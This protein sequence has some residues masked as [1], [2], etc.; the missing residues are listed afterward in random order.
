MIKKI[1]IVALG[2]CMATCLSAQKKL[3][4]KK[5]VK[6][7]ER[8]EA[9]GNLARAAE[10]YEQAWQKKNS[11]K[12]LIFKAADLYYKIK[13]YRKA[14][15]SYEYVKNDNDDFPLVGLKF[16]RS[17]KQDGQ[18][19]KAKSAFQ[20]FL[21]AYSGQGKSILQDVIRKEVIGCELASKLPLKANR[22]IE[23]KYIENVNSDN[24]EISPAVYN[25]EMFFAANKGRKI[26]IFNTRKVG[27]NWGTI[28]NPNAFPIINNGNYSN[29]C[30]SPNGSKLYFTICDNDNSLDELRARCEIFYTERTSK[31]WS[32][33]QRLPDYI[34]QDGVTATTPF[35]F[36]SGGKEILYFAS[37]RE[38]G[39]GGLD[40]WYS[41]RELNGGEFTFPVNLGSTVNTLGDELS[42]YYD[43]NNGVLFFSSN[44]Q[45][46]IGGYDI[47]Q[48][49]GNNETWST[50][51]NIGLPFNSSADDFSYVHSS[52]GTAG[53]IVS[54]RVF[55][56]EKASTR[57]TDIFEFELGSSN[58]LVLNGNVY[59][60]QS[61]DLIDNFTVTLYQVDDR[62]ENL[63]F[64]R[65]F[66][67]GAYSSDLLPDRNFR[68]KVSSPGYADMDYNIT[69]DDPNTKVYGQ[70]IFLIAD[71]S[72]N[73]DPIAG[74]NHSDGDLIGED[75]GD[76]YTTRGL[77][78][79]DNFAFV[80][81]APRYKGVYF[82]IQL[83]ALM[84]YNPE[85]ELYQ[86]VYS[87]GRL[88]TESLI[89]KDLTRV[90]LA[91][92]FTR[93]EAFSMLTQVQELGFPTAFV[94][95]YEDGE[96][97]GRIKE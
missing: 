74:G 97:Y 90:L 47:F 86:Q 23:L 95:K 42:P 36:E 64:S 94:V 32:E 26:R 76:S 22:S 56:G 89:D 71:G 14:A 50:P 72:S 10:H 79:D 63:L 6:E 92:F 38:N 82:K 19:D 59:D 40:L 61:G 4:W 54:N 69:T 78:P 60:K 44:G 67:N 77:A 31:G 11:K 34:N 17:L 68:V 46:T 13:D 88:D 29:P 96:R 80:T 49:N 28:S 8:L 48:T 20:T 84:D 2:I 35:V 39:R 33:P 21:D 57:H 75:S 15:A 51:Q 24:N 41:T 66:A 3:N 83:A 9:A 12:D 37:N 30:F 53:Y 25:N 16:A 43:Q 85:R 52:D 81:N 1:L 7:A 55:G 62:G 73:A 91:D 87:M 70:P 18:Y 5:H 45:V 93:E 65:D 27:S 58:R